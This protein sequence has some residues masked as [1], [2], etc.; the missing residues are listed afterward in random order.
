MAKRKNPATQA[1]AKILAAIRSHPEA[2][3]VDIGGR[4]MLFLLCMRGAKLA[5][6]K[7]RDPI[8]AIFKTLEHLAPAIQAS[9]LFVDGVPSDKDFTP[10]V[11]L[12]V[13]SKAVTGEFL[14][15]LTTVIW[16]GVLA[17]QPDVKLEEIEILVTPAG[18]RTIASTVWPKMVS[19]AQDLDESDLARDDSKGEDD[20]GTEGN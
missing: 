7:G 3:E 10:A 8:P 1:N 6:E 2:V 18:I 13:L 17:A 11:I 12:S 9:G 20:G 16:W 19:Y 15:D 4:T 5:R 14:E